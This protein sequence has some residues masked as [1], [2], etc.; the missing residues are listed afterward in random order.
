M[1][2]LT[3]SRLVAAIGVLLIAVVSL[4]A[5][6]KS[7]PRSPNLI[8]TPTSTGPSSTGTPT[9]NGQLNPADITASPTSLPIAW[10]PSEIALS[11]PT[12]R[13]TTTTITLLANVSLQDAQVFV[14]PE[15]KRFMVAQTEIFSK[16]DA[17]S[18]TSLQFAFLVPDGTAVGEYEGTVHIRVGNQTLPQTLKISLTVAG[19]P[20]ADWPVFSNT[21]VPY[22]IKYPPDWSLKL[23]A[24]GT[25]QLFTSPS[26]DPM[27]QPD[28]AINIYVVDNPGSLAPLDFLRQ[29]NEKGITA[30]GDSEFGY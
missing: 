24:S 6:K 13:L 23:L 2:K 18:A 14:V 28:A 11:L 25:L 16:L 15:L 3:I 29:T 1:T 17:G 8:S 21:S 7:F 19:S 9:T 4:N 22:Q 27:A 30:E 10:T 12:G 20:T 26:N 5:A